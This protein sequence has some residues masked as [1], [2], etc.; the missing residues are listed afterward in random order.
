MDELITVK[1]AADRLQVHLLTVYR[2]ISSGVLP[3]QRLPGGWLRIEANEL[4][5]LL[6][7]NKGRTN[8][9]SK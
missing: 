6:S 5:R 4:E 2:W 9:K 3:A 8:V 1:Q 7:K